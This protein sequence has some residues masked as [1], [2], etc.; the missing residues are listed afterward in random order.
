MHRSHVHRILCSASALVFALAL[1]VAISGQGKEP[2][3]TILKG[4][5]LGGVKL[6]HKAHTATYGAKCESCHHASKP[7]KPMKGAQQKCSDCHTKAAA[8]PMKT[9][10]RAAF[11]DA[12]A[13]KGVCI[14]CHVPAAAKGKK[15][16]VKCNDCHKKENV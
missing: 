8:A 16:P 7:E 6:D 4:A 11:H 5:P 12:T 10:T 14:D 1:G 2:D 15:A 13:K 3:T 9:N